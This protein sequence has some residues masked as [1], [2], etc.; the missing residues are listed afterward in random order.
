METL[1]PN[2]S[3]VRPAVK[4]SLVMVALVLLIIAAARP[5]FGQSER[6]EKRQG[7]EAIVA[8]DISNSMLAEDVAPNRLDR[9]KQMLSKLMD[10]MINDKVGLVVF[11]GDAFVQLPITC[12]Y[13]SAKMFLNT[14]K[15]ELIKTQGTAIGQA[16]S[17]SIRCFGEQSEAS[18]AIILITDGE[19]HEDD[20]VAVAKRAKEAGIQV[21]VV[22]IGKPEGS[23]IP[24]PGT[25]NFR[26][27][28]EGNVVVS[29]LNE[30]MCREI[31]QAGGGIYVRCDNSN[32]ATKAIQK[33]L[34]KLATQ[35]IETQVYTDYNEQF[36]SFAL[37]AL[38]LLVIDFF[39][40]NRKNKA[41]TKLD[42]FGE[43]GKWKMENG[44]WS[45]LALMLLVSL[46]TFAQQESSDV[47]RGNKDY[48][49]QNYTAAE[50]NYRRGLEKNK[51]GYEAHY[52]LGDAL[53]KQDKYADAQT[54][55]ETAAKIL[56]KDKDKARYAKAMHNI[57]NC[58]FAQQQYG[59]AVGAYQESL[60]AN[61]KDDDTRYNLVKAMQLL[62]QQQ[63]Q[64][65]QQQNQQNQDQQQE[66]Q[67]E[68]QQQQQQQ[69]QQQEQQQ[70]EDQ[71]DK[72]T[73]EQILQA[74]E[75]DE[76]DTQEKMQRQQGKKRR[77]E[78]EW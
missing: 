3:R 23:P 34:D 67:Q 30:E 1:M 42:I 55:F 63:Q 15:P 45:F 39:I 58:A 6:T 9:A 32:T 68:Q 70:N 61:P 78:K 64:Q 36:Q 31:A 46:S 66:Q 29:K 60:R 22:G 26:K 73:A 43:N 53:F 77:V 8:L 49:K 56:D 72:E 16:L 11:A 76:Q 21:L 10:N 47:R 44:K 52:N 12:D 59:Q 62:Q 40:F 20:A 7:I 75:Q 74:L 65:Q 57:G 37:I 4:F 71:M 14:I 33:E 18:R 13:V 5:Q 38:L 27:D 51:N 28:R 24:M 35:E 41:L 69:E 25:N 2:A 48:R 50:V 19:N 17:T 54:E